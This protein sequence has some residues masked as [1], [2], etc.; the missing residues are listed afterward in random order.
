[1]KNCLMS[2]A[3]KSTRTQKRPQKQSQ[4]TLCQISEHMIRPRYREQCC[5]N[6]TRKE[7]EDWLFVGVAVSKRTWS[8]PCRPKLLQAIA[9]SK[10]NFNGMSEGHFQKPRA[11]S[12]VQAACSAFESCLTR[13][14]MRERAITS[15][16]GYNL[17]EQ[18]RKG[19]RKESRVSLFGLLPMIDS[20]ED[21]RPKPCFM[22]DNASTA[23]PISARIRAEIQSQHRPNIN[24]CQNNGHL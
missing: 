15:A 4:A 17:I 13:L 2:I 1:M 7:N 3:S 11:I 24:Y 16:A 5:Q 23:Y 8:T 20:Q 10:K 14:V 18:P 19:Y 9:I 6:P 12:A 22:H 21:S